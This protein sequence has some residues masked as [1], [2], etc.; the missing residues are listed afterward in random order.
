VRRRAAREGNAYRSWT[1]T[2]RTA[3]DQRR[4]VVAFRKE[5]GEGQGSWGIEGPG[6]LLGE[7]ATQGAT[8]VRE[9]RSRKSQSLTAHDNH[10]HGVGEDLFDNGVVALGALVPLLDFSGV[11]EPGTVLG[12]H[13][14]A[15]QVAVDVLRKE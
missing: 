11:I 3:P 1:R 10:G 6:F 15:A 14:R 2:G 5:G 7:K 12:R 13:F 8:T 4:M 9:K